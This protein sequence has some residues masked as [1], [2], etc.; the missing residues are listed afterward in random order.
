LLLFKGVFRICVNPRDLGATPNW[1]AAGR[2]ALLSIRI[3]QFREDFTTD[4]RINRISLEQKGT[5]GT[6]ANLFF[7]AFVCFC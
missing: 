1:I 4:S 2:D 3:A 6:K 7:V 5:K